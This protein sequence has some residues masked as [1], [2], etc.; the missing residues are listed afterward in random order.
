MVAVHSGVVQRIVLGA[1]HPNNFPRRHRVPC[2]TRGR[3]HVSPLRPVCVDVPHLLRD[4]AVGSRRPVALHGEEGR[5]L[6]VEERTDRVVGDCRAHRE[7]VLV[8]LL[9][10]R[11]KRVDEPALVQHELAGLDLTTLQQLDE[12]VIRL[13]NDPQV[14]VQLMNHLGARGHFL[15][16]LLLVHLPVT[17]ELERDVLQLTVAQVPLVFRLERGNSQLLLGCLHLGTKICDR[18]L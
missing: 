8:L 7:R 13:V 2:D 18:C 9:H 17:L 11:Q 10:D 3:R 16:P 4:F 14:R 12:L 6:T 15:L 5:Q 1:H